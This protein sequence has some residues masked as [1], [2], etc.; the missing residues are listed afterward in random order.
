MC[1]CIDSI[2]S[3]TFSDFELL[4]IYDCSTDNTWELLC[5]YQRKDPRIVLVS[6]SNQGPGGARNLGISIAKGKYWAFWDSDDIFDPYV[7]EKMFLS[8]ENVDAEIVVCS[9][10][11]LR[12]GKMMGKISE[13]VQLELLPKKEVFSASDC[14]DSLFEAFIGWAWD[15][16]FRASFCLDL[17]L[18]F[19]DNYILEDGAFVFSALANASRITLIQEQLIFHRIHVDSLEADGAQFNQHWRDVFINAAAIQENIKKNPGQDLQFRSSFCRWLL[20]FCL[21]VLRKTSGEA[22][23]AMCF[24]MSQEIQGTFGFSVSELRKFCY[25]EDYC[26]YMCFVCSTAETHYTQLKRTIVWKIRKLQKGA[27]YLA[28]GHGTEII[29]RL[30]TINRQESN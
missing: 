4:C 9:S 14:S 27:R 26:T 15:K 11:Y 16:L 30:Y 5:R 10:S 12:N 19:G 1:P 23:D 17:G 28:T 25:W 21:W 20:N 18:Q 29:Q 7:L 13:A 8:A 2:L 6:G 3:Q 24:R 22:F